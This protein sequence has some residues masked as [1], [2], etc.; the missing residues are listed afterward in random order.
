M[1]SA[2]LVTFVALLATAF[3]SPVLEAILEAVLQPPS[4]TCSPN[5]QGQPLTI[6]KTRLA[7]PFQWVPTNAVG[8][9]IT[10]VFTKTPF[11]TSEFLVAFS[12]QPDNSYVFKL[13]FFIVSSCP[14]KFNNGSTQDDS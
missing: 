1:F 11:A 2:K 7:F 3:A 5:F 9:H 14:C 12:G 6:F 10:L 13:V 8:G 4:S